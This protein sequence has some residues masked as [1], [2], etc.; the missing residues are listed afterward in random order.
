MKTRARVSFFVGLMLAAAMATHAWAQGTTGTITGRV[1]DGSGGLLPGATVAISSPA[2]IGGPRESVTD[3]LG[4]YRFTAVPPGTYR[5]VFS[6]PGFQTLTVE[7][8]TLLAGATM[9]V[10]GPL[11]LDS[12]SE[13]IT[14][15][16]TTPT[17]PVE[18]A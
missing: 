12:V 8:V 6:L 13:S 9:T 10:N 14:V 15:T 5:V 3:G 7:G 11:Q 17:F 4:T 1:A 2:M 16:S 18:R